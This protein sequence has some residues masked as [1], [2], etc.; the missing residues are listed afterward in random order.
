MVSFPV[1]KLV[2]LIS[3]HLFIFAFISFA[4]GDWVIDL[5]YN[6]WS[7]FIKIY[8]YIRLH[9]CLIKEKRQQQQLLNFYYVLSFVRFASGCHI[10]SFNFPESFGIIPTWQ[11]K[12]LTFGNSL[13][14]DRKAQVLIF[15][16][17]NTVDFSTILT[18]SNKIQKCL[19]VLK[20]DSL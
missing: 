13:C 9:K 16:D 7:I 20:Y 2:Y 6:Q 14:T 3:S 1:Q 8:R 17:S 11:M 18:A 4:L 15:S 19:E 12:K 5:S 10:F